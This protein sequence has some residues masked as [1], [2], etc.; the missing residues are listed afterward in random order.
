MSQCCKLGIAIERYDLNETEVTYETIDDHLYARW[1]GRAGHSGEGY[2]SLTEWFNK[3]ILERVYDD[4]G[5]DAIRPSLDAEYEVLTGDN[6]IARQELFNDLQADDIRGKHLL[7]GFVSWGTMR[8][9]LKECLEGEKEQQQ[10]ET[11]WERRSVEIAR[12]RT[13]EKAD[14]ALR[15][16]A[17]KGTLPQGDAAGVTVQVQLTCPECPTRIP[18]TKAVDRGF[19]CNQHRPAARDDDPTA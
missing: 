15:S 10:A 4:H 3:R 16:L 1:V 5:R 2:R 14:A 13:R 11:D 7:R 6:D 17:S 12:E 9:H 8:I 19:V 18:F